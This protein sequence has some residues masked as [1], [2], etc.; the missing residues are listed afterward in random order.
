[1]GQVQRLIHSQQMTVFIPS[2]RIENYKLNSKL[3]AIY[4]RLFLF[5]PDTWFAAVIAFGE[6]EF[7]DIFYFR[8]H[9]ASVA[10]V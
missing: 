9:F 7:S 2:K 10:H 6:F 3:I 1:M 8:C 5:L 4:L